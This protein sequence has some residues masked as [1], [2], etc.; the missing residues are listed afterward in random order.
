MGLILGPLFA[1]LALTVVVLPWVNCVRLQRQQ[2][3]LRA[4]RKAVQALTAV[5]EPPPAT[6]TADSMQPDPGGTTAPAA[7]TPAA[8]P[9]AEHAAAADSETMP[10]APSPVAPLPNESPDTPSTGGFERRFGALLPVWVGGVALAL[11]GFFLV[12]YSIEHELLSPLARVLLG[13]A[14]GVGLLGAAGWVR[15]KPDF[16]NGRRIAQSLSGA[17]VAV[18]YICLF[19]SVGLY[20]LLAPLPGFLG[21]AVLTGAAVVLSLRHGM[22]IALLG[23]VGGF[24]TP[25]LVGSSN[26]SAPLLF[27][28]LFCIFGGLMTVIKRQNWWLLSL[29]A[30]LGAFLWVLF[31]IFS[32]SVS[33]DAI[34][35]GLFL[36][37]VSATIVAGSPQHSATGGGNRLGLGAMLNYAGLGGAILLMGLLV[38]R[39]DFGLL[40]W[41]LFFCLAAGG[42]VLAGFDERRYGF[43][44]WVSMAV[45]AVMLLVW[46][47][48]SARTFALV[49]AG[50][51]VLYA[52][53][54]WFLLWRSR[55]PLLWAGLAAAVSLGFYLLAYYKLQTAALFDGIPLF[56]GLLAL[57][58]CGAAVYA[59]HETLKRAIERTQQAYLLTVFVVAAVAFSSLALLVELEYMFLPVAFAVQVPLLAWLS[60]RVPVASLRSVCIVLAVVFAGLLLPQLIVLLQYTAYSLTGIEAIATLLRRSAPISLAEWPLFQLGVPALLLL[61][62]AGWLRRQRDGAPV[63]ALEAAAAG[64]GAVMVYFLARHAFHDAT[65]IISAPAGFTERGVATNLLLVYSL[66]CLFAGRRFGRCALAWS[67]ATICAWALLRILYFDLLLHN[68]LW[69][70]QRIDGWPVLNTLLLTFGLPL[71]WIALS[72]RELQHI[73]WARWA[74]LLRST[75]PV[76][77]FVLVSLNVRHLFQ[78]EYLNLR[79][80][81]ETEIYTYSAVWLLFGIGLLLVGVLK[82]NQAIRYASLAVM[83]LV[84]SKV[85]LYDTL[86]LQ[87]LY[88]VLSFFGLGFSLLGLSYIYSRFVFTRPRRDAPPVD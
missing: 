50:F 20:D 49:L 22:P 31:W 58:L 72:S 21:M 55:M 47:A 68:P 42:I 13:S 70:N 67:G 84:V 87:G 51:A 41:A 44:P 79:A 45:N 43:V 33:H 7:A 76:L 78:G 18:L 19:A 32:R 62:A 63:R 52:G 1:L 3:E 59:G 85:F 88:R 6:Q 34:W 4:L 29:P 28:Y 81:Q 26:P 10:V 80:A 73:G 9:P 37:G 46:Q 23:L 17:G 64:L 27:I 66:A 15:S 74:R 16:A 65:A 36:L 8:S 83:L 82:Q 75:I 61:A 60:N 56:W 24:L 40:E 14:L 30:L 86:E 69:T 2:E 77:L 35:V 53:S 48:E 25:A 39:A 38:A 12:K 5:A 71:A 57:A 54:G 11:A